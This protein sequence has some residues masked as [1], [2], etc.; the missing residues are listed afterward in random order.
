MYKFLR[1][2]SSKVDTEKIE[3]TVQG[4]ERKY[5]ISFPSAVKDYALEADGASIKLCCFEIDGYVCE[6]SKIIP[7][8]NG[9]LTFEKIADNDR[10]DGFISPSL[11]PLASNRG[12]DFYYWD[13][14]SDAV[15]LIFADDIENPFKICSSTEEFFNLLV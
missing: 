6:V 7:V 5:G 10:V 1:E 11:Y 15:Y 12:G 3:K 8:C 14:N 2:P 13:A 9:N 4:L